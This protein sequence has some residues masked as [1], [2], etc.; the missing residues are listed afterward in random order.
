METNNI[1]PPHQYGFRPGQ[2]TET[3]ITTIYETIAMAQ[4]DRF[5]TNVVCRDISKA[6]DKI[7]HNGLKYK[8]LTLNLPDIFE[9]ILASFLDDRSAALKIDGIVGRPFK[10]KSGVPQGSILSPTLFL[11]YTA[12]MPPPGPGTLDITFADDV[13]QIV[14]HPHRSREYLARKTVREIERVNEYEKKWKIKT[15]RTKFKLISITKRKPND[16]EVEGE[17]IPFAR[18]STVLG[19]TLRGSGLN[20]HIT[21]RLIMAKAQ[22]AKLRRFRKLSTKSKMRFFK[23]L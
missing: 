5:Q 2:G 14:I 11:F 18:T 21:Q 4:R 3:A 13:T 9:K 8:V 6:F 1:L 17:R 12:A 15:N 7:W 20:T 22:R 16:V 19:L 10:I 23:T